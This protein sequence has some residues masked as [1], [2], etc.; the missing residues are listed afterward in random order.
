M[1]DFLCEH[2]R[3]KWSPSS[4]RPT[5]KAANPF[6]P[7]WNKTHHLAFPLS[8]ARVWALFQTIVSNW[9]AHRDARQGAALAYYSIFSL[10][11]IAIIAIAVAGLLL[12]PETVRTDFGSSLKNLLGE[13][14]AEGVQNML[15]G[16]DEPNEGVTA[17]AIG[18]GTLLFAAVGVVV[19]L[20]DALNTIWEVPNSKQSGVW[21]FVRTYILSL[22][23]VIGVGF[24]LLVS[25]VFTAGLAA[26]GQAYGQLFSETLLQPVGSLVSLLVI[27]ALFAAIFRWLPDANV[28]WSDVWLGALLTALLFEIGKFVIGFYIGRQGLESSFGGAASLVIVLIWVYYTA[29]L[30][31]L[32][33]EFTY[34]MALRRRPRSSA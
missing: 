25:L 23:G 14:G 26:L 3:R 29:Q 2:S 22:A 24:L 31:L 30:V 10:G 13:Q 18:I 9:L 5:K 33:A 6:A 1:T 19:Q 27:A 32:G 16:A 11:P 17:S 8:E 4:Q 20:K 28:H 34:A 15:S 7:H 12:D 21:Y